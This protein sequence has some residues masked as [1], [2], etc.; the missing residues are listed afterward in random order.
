M[1]ETTQTHECSHILSSGHVAQGDRWAGR[2]RRFIYHNRH[3]CRILA[4]SEPT[5]ERS[6][7]HL[8]R[9]RVHDGLGR[10]A[11]QGLPALRGVV[12]RS[13]P[14][15]SDADRPVTF[16]NPCPVLATRHFVAHHRDRH[17]GDRY[18]DECPRDTLPK[19]NRCCVPDIG[20]G[21]IFRDA[22]CRDPLVGHSAPH[23]AF[24][25]QES[26]ITLSKAFF[27]I[28]SHDGQWRGLR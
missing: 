25:E 12:V 18:G 1:P 2:V 6:H 26:E 16:R 9:A 20:T 10:R 3:R 21:P 28:F 27:C 19:E 14:R 5:R 8:Y 11:P 7:E 17:H 24:V 4:R 15:P 23:I 22:T 13:S